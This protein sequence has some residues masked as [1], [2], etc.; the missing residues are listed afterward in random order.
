[1]PTTLIIL[2]CLM[3]WCIC[4]GLS[5]DLQTQKGY[6][7]GF[8]IGFL[9]GIIGLIYSAGLPDKSK[10]QITIKDNE[11]IIESIREEDDEIED[12]EICPKCGNQIFSDEDKCSNCGREKQKKHK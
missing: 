12:I 3:V 8:V 4:G 9:L 6:D 5:K 1:M 7:G 2:M 10:K 11:Q